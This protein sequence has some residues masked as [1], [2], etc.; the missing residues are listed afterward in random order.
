MSAPI[1]T[2]DDEIDRPGYY[3]PPFKDGDTYQG[4]T[5]GGHSDFAVDWNRRTPSGGWL[6]DDGEPVRA[7]ADGRVVK[8]TP[9]DGY[10]MLQH[11]DLHRSEYRHMEPVLVKVGQK[12]R[13]GDIIGRIGEA[14]NA[15]SGTHLHH[16]QLERSAKGRPFRAVKQTFYGKPIA[17]SVGD[18]DSRPESWDPPPPA[19]VIGPPAPVTWEDSYREAARRLEKAE[20]RLLSQEGV[21]RLTTQERDTARA[22]VALVRETADEL[23]TALTAAALRIKELENA[24][25]ADCSRE[26][27]RIARAIAALTEEAP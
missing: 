22:E 26:Q 23:R 4:I 19:Y 10:V 27:G 3:Y 21:I 5:Y 1:R 20:D 7:I 12:V 2:P 24:T 25:P 14:G 15:P 18:S 11:G 13:R 6:P 17:T 9:A 16:E 8:T